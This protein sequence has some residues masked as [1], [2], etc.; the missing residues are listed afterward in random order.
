MNREYVIDLVVSI[1]DTD[2]KE[3]VSKDDDVS[4]RTI[5][6]TSMKAMVLFGKL[7]E[8]F[9]IDFKDEDLNFENMDS[10]NKIVKLIKKYS[11]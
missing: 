4:L 10:I 7:E 5:G 11:H 3:F 2:C 1:I 9:K 8:K 6:L